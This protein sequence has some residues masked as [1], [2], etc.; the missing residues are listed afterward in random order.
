EGIHTEGSSADTEVSWLALAK[1][2]QA[3][4][5]AWAGARKARKRTTR[6]LRALRA[7]RCLMKGNSSRAREGGR[8]PSW[9][10]EIGRCGEL[11]LWE[12]AHEA[13]E[14]TAP[15]EPRGLPDDAPVHLA[16]AGAPVDERDRDLLDAESQPPHLVRHL[17][18][19]RVAVGV[20][21]P[22]IQGTERPP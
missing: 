9:A 16:D 10:T 3:P 12:L 2:C 14:A 20:H 17:D 15:H 13:H 22:Q 5:S 21:A 1:A 4:A 18:L 6:A 11:Q 7:R 19:E 8:A